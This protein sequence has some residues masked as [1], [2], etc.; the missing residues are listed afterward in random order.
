MFAVTFD[1]ADWGEFAALIAAFAA[2]FV[3]FMN[4]RAMKRQA[5]LNA[6]TKISDYREA[7]IQ[8]LRDTFV[9]MIALNLMAQPSREDVDRA[10]AVKSKTILL[11]NP[12]DPNFDMITDLSAR[13][14]LQIMMKHSRQ[15][16]VE[17]PE[18]LSPGLIQELDDLGGSVASDYQK[19]GQ[20][21]L[22][23]EWDTLKKNLESSHA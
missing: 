23:N 10:A 3:G 16:K 15:N 18:I 17:F 6:E 12:N 21:I 2:L 9:E 13:M 4:S 14:W 11:L 20:T 1:L 7:W 22:K 19:I 8:R 5:S